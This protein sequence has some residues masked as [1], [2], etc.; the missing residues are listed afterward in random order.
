MNVTFTRMTDESKAAELLTMMRGL[1]AEDA[2]AS[3]VVED[4]FPRTI[5]F[6]LANPER[7]QIFLFY[8]GELLKGYS[9]LIPFW[10]NEFG[11]TL[12]YV[13][14]IYVISKA[15]NLGIGRAFFSFLERTRPFD[16][17]A[18]ALEVSPSNARARRLYES[19]GF[20]LRRNST[21]TR[22]LDSLPV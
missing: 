7:G 5:D 10:S 19:I 15:R 13:D 9:I 17:V 2:P 20:E 1:Y 11:G 16:A 22:R 18:I 8:D 3:S 14:E 21:F 12:L 4:R 6:L